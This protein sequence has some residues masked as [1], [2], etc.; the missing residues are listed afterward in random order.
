M[1]VN[2]TKRSHVENDVCRDPQ[3]PVVAP[4]ALAATAGLTKNQAVVLQC[5]T[6]RTNS[7][8]LRVTEM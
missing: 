4:V 5:H 1:K 7:V 2:G 6:I 8:V 3:E